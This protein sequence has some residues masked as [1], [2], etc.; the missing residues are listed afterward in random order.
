LLYAVSQWAIYPDWPRRLGRLPWLMLLGTGI[1]LSN[2]VAVAQALLR[3][4]GLFQRTP[5][6]RI[7][8]REDSWRGNPY[9]LG[10]SPMILGELALAG[11]ALA[12]A[13]LA[14]ASGHP[15]IIPYLLLYAGGFGYAGGLA[16]LQSLEQVEALALRPMSGLTL[17]ALVGRIVRHLG[18]GMVQ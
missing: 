18:R 12:G 9:A 8:S 4:P 10:F 5:K 6:F 3:S 17:L 11:Y 13:V 1:A 7:E 14:G 15:F 2:T 16:L